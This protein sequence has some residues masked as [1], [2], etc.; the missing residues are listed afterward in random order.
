[1]KRAGPW[2]LQIEVRKSVLL[3]DSFINGKIEASFNKSWPVVSSKSIFFEYLY[4]IFFYSPCVAKFKVFL[5]VVRLVKLK[6]AFMEQF[7]YNLVILIKLY[8][9][10]Y[11]DLDKTLLFPRDQAIGLENW[12][13][14]RAPTAEKFDIFWW[15][16]AHVS[17]LTM[18]I[19]E[20]PGFCFVLFRSWVINKNVKNECLETMSFLI[21]ANNSRSKENKKKIP[22]TLF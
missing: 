11:L 2:S 17:Y 4:F 5:K 6:L 3:M 9:M 10:R 14:W 22:T 7:F 18:S 1:M 12:K 16:F 20:C 8:K 13:L 15:N 21:S 19:K